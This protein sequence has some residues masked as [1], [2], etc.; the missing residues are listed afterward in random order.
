MIAAPIIAMQTP[1]TRAKPIFSPSRITPNNSANGTSSLL[2]TAMDAVLSARATER[3]SDRY[4]PAPI[5]NPIL[6]SGAIS[7]RGTR[8]NPTSKTASRP[9]RMPVKRI[10]GNSR[11][12]ITAAINI[13]PHSRLINTASTV[14][15]GFMRC[16][17]LLIADPI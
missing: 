14:C 13:D 16:A 17:S 11:N 12:P 4:M 2:N 8:K 9:K 7:E 3:Y 6:K 5:T 15:H 10:G 1:A